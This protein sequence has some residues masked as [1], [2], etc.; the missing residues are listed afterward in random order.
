MNLRGQLYLAGLIGA[1][2]SY[3]FNVLAFTGEFNV[4]RWSVFIVVFLVVFVG[5]EKLIAWAD[6]PEAN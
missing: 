3:I 5:F 6:S 1:S 2:I 4:I